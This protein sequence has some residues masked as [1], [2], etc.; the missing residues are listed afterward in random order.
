MEERRAVWSWALYDWANSAFATVVLAGFFPILFGGLWSNDVAAVESNYRLGMINAAAGAFI[1]VSAPVLGALADVGGFKK[2]MLAI[3][4]VLGATATGLLF[5][6]DAGQWVAAGLLYIAG[7]IGFM[8][9]NIFYDALLISVAPKSRWHFV[10]GLGF[11]LGY[12]GGGLLYAFCVWMAIAPQRFGFADATAAAQ[13]SFLLVA[14][15]WAVFALPVLV[16]VNDRPV[17]RSPRHGL[18]VQAFKQVWRTLRKIRSHRNAAVF[19]LAYWFYIDGV[20]T[21]IRMAV[22]YGTS[23]GFGTEDL[24]KALLLTQFIGFPAAIIYG[25]L[26]ERFTAKRSLYAGLVTYVGIC[27]WGTQIHSAAEFY[28][29]AV[30]IGLVQGGV[31]SVSRSF[32][33]GLIPRQESAEFFGFYNLLGKFATLLGPPLFAIVGREAGDVRYSILSLILLFAI[34]M[35]L[36]S[37]VREEQGAER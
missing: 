1:A 31:Q 37:R 24:I 23:L 16:W 10:S 32:F 2:R 15:W 34:G 25:K 22:A 4:M 8:A 20:D 17:S 6:V 12:L 3:F 21:I 36:L 19:L 30:L 29:V 14:G 35:L 33:A 11:G 5:F 18:A 7:S 27:I 13:F 26:S 9:A 28:G